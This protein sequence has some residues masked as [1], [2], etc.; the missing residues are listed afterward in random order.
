MREAIRRR[1]TKGYIEL[2]S[3]FNNMDVDKSKSLDFEEFRKAVIF[4]GCDLDYEGTK[5]L[6]EDFDANR[7]GS[8]SLDEF[9]LGVRGKM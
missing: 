5:L 2:V 9:I 8:I 7:N 1:G 3:L 6:F 4:I